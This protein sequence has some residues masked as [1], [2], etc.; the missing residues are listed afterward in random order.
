MRSK[1]Y[2]LT[3]RLISCFGDSLYSI[4]IMWYVFEKT[5][6]PLIT[7]IASS[8]LMLPM[9]LSVFAGPLI[10]HFNRKK[11]MLGTQIIQMLLMATIT[12][13]FLLNLMPLPLLIFSFFVIG[14]L[15]IFE[16]NAE[17]ALA[18]MIMSEDELIKFNSVVV[19]GNLIISSVAKAI[20]V[21]IILSLGIESIYIINF[22]TFVF[23]CLMF[24]KVKYKHS[25]QGSFSKQQYKHSILEGITYFKQY[26]LI[27]LAIPAMIANFTGAMSQA[28]LPAFTFEKGGELAYG[29]FLTASVIFGA[30]GSLITPKLKNID[31]N[32]QITVAPIFSGLFIFSSVLFENYFDSMLFYGL[33]ALPLVIM[34]IGTST[35]IQTHVDNK[36]LSRVGTILSAICTAVMP[37]GALLGGWLGRIFNPD[38]SIYIT[39]L[40]FFFLGIL[41]LSRRMRGK[42]V[43]AIQKTP[44]IS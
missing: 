19:T 2:L 35:Y 44:H 18:P 24:V 14:M 37:I 41:F 33:S 25:E 8:V 1:D 27:W 36:V 29:Y 28:I 7:G 15:E 30:F 3:G 16:G 10:D 23:A 9:V 5:K 40:G 31:I 38:I 21:F 17:H 42:P 43:I 12:V 11:L 13:L 4:A 34:N 20:C 32:L 22:I 6:D 26:G 39:S